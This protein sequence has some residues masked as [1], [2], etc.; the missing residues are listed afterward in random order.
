M[1]SKCKIHKAEKLIAFCKQ[2]KCL[3]AI[4][5]SCLLTDHK[6]HDIVMLDDLKENFELDEKVKNKK[7]T[8]NN[9]YLQSVP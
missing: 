5:F 4:C 7:A 9:P 6:N 1:G 3:E 8:T 2:D